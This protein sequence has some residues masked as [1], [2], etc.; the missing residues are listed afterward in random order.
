MVTSKIDATGSDGT[1]AKPKPKKPPEPKLQ[2]L[3]DDELVALYAL[4]K[5]LY[6]EQQPVA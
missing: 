1:P 3:S 2:N 6:Y 5:K 4:Q